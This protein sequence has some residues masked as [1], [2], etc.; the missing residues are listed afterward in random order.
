MATS[1]ARIPE[2]FYQH[3]GKG[4]TKSEIF[5]GAKPPICKITHK[6]VDELLNLCKQR[7]FWC[8][9]LRRRYGYKYGEYV[10][11]FQDSPDTSIH[12]QFEVPYLLTGF[13]VTKEIEDEIRGKTLCFKY[14]RDKTFFWPVLFIREGSIERERLA[15]E[16]TR[17]MKNKS[18]Q[19][20][21]EDLS[22]TTK[23][24]IR[25]NNDKSNKE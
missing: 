7:D 16:A 4:S 12:R 8:L 2:A 17:P 11:E 19:V 6:A 24:F 22:Q 15:R 13:S 20:R 14:L 9:E 25:N 18:E 5:P 1:L 21:F 3:K 23:D 10:W